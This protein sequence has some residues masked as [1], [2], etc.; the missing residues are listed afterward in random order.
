MIR[1]YSNASDLK[2]VILRYFNVAG[3][4]ISGRLGQSSKKAAHLIK[5]ACDAALGVRDAVSIFGTDYPTADGT[6]IRDYIH[7]EDLA[8]AHVDALSYLQKS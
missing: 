2:Y 6:G 5:I 4:D 7:I 3:A 8:S 1:D